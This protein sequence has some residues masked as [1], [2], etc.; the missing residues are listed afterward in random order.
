MPFDE[1]EDRRFTDPLIGEIANIWRLRQDMVRAQA[2]LTLQTKAIMRRLCG[3]DKV[4]AGKLYKAVTKGEDHPLLA[5]AFGAVE[6]F[7]DAGQPLVKRRAIFEKELAK[8]GKA[9]P[10]AYTADLIKGV[11]HMTLAAIV[12]ECG[13]LSAYR[14]VFAVWKRAGLAV[15]DGKR[16]RRVA[17]EA[18]FQHG[19]SPERRSVFYNVA[20]ALFKAQGKDENA[21][22]YRR[23]YDARKAIE[24]ERVETAGHAHNRALRHMTKELV[25]H[26]TLEW[27]IVAGIND[28]CDEP[29]AV[30]K[31]FTEGQCSPAAQSHTVLG[32]GHPDCHKSGDTQ[33]DA[34]IGMA[35]E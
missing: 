21:G 12:G 13:D 2:K 11:N 5:P 22:P 30:I 8:R 7:L 31:R 27:R 1:T 15:I 4:E 20:E 6:S 10:I 16:Q 9:M 29:G 18:A 25:K 26:L 24:L 3:G 33:S 19:Y 32:D 14:S 28:H 35:A 17:G 23:F 34:A